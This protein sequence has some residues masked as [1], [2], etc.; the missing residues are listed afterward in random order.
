MFGRGWGRFGLLL[1]G[2][3]L[4]AP[5]C[6]ASTFTRVA[7]PLPPGAHASFDQSLAFDQHLYLADGGA[8]AVDVL[9]IS[10][11]RPR[12][13]KAV[14][15]AGE[16]KGLAVDPELK[17]VFVGLGNG[18]I[19][20]IDANPQSA[21]AY[22]LLAAYATGE[23]SLDLLDY[24]SRDRRVYAA[25]GSGRLVGIDIRGQVVSRITLANGLEQPRYD[26]S[27]SL[28]Y[29]N[30]SD[31]NSIYTI[32][33]RAGRLLSERKLGATCAPTGMGLD[34]QHGRALLGCSDPGASAVLLWD[35]VHG[36]LADR[37][38]NI[39]D[40]D[41]VVYDAASDRYLVAGAVAGHTAVGVLGGSPV[42]W[43]GSVTTSA[44]TRSV[45]Y[46]SDRK[47]IY[48]PVAKT[49]TAAV[50]SFAPPAPEGGFP[51][52]D[53]ML[54]LLYLVVLV[55]IG[56]AIWMIGSRRA[57]ERARRGRPMFS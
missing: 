12:F 21:R 10:G 22:S 51:W 53:L 5:A 55:G 37:F 31:R 13:L 52:G 57:H 50:V 30:D 47:V 29:V 9:D 4:L 44:D 15:V 27:R 25:A 17:R 36:K 3:L 20:V 23:T 1:A 49:D 33:P 38:D 11:D 28:L 35:V 40:A 39:A 6:A 8:K 56:V 26:A 54:P 16:P 41:Q 32:D 46:D 34:A 14:A 2:C 48:Q 42:R 45:A 7:V 43:I 19:G 18:S 24:D